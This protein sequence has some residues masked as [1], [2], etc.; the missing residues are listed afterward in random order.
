MAD[1][2]T[3]NVSGS[4]SVMGIW[5]GEE[6]KS[7]QAVIDG[8][9]EQYPGRD[10]Q[11]QPAGD[12]LPT[13]LSTAVEGGN[14]PDIAAI[15]Q[16]GLMQ[17]F[18]EQGALEPLDFV[19][20]GAVGQL[21]PIGG[22]HRLGRRQVLRSDVEGRQQVDR[23]VQ[24]RRL[25]GRRRRGARDL[26]RLPHGGRDAARRPACRRT[27]SRGA[28]GWTLTDLF[29]NIYIR[30]AGPEK[31]DQLAE[32]RD[33]VDR[34]VGQGRADRDGEGVRGHAT[35]SPAA[36]RA[37]SRPTS[38]PRSATS[39]RRRPKAAMVI[40]ADFVPGVV[41][42]YARSRRRGST[43]S[44]SRR[45]RTRRRRSSAAGNLFI[46]FRTT[47]RSRRSSST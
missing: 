37:H 40:E 5:M 45:S 46:M 35:T 23:L 15:A 34:P 22:R 31:Y 4:I 1:G 18:I 47:P 39:S 41:E 20:R 8:F 12:N 29:E 17:G 38:R 27:R 26:G 2:R 30:T 9:N 25:R 36:P 11:V 43:S 42:T 3:A 33:P 21:R 28:D 24:R 13:V 10:R 7:F 16:P 6:Q 44:R 32:A 14:P 19:E